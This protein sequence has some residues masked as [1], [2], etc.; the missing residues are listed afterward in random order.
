MFKNTV[1][2]AALLAGFGALFLAIGSFFGTGG[3]D[4]RPR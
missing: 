4:H 2:T 1:K 3:L